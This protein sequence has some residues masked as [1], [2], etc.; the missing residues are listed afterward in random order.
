MIKVFN[1]KWR[2]IG[3]KEPEFWMKLDFRFREYLHHF[4]GAQLGVF[5]AITLHTDENGIAYPSYDLLEKETGYGRDTIGRALNK[6]CKTKINDQRVLMRFRERNDNGQYEGSNRYLIF[7]LE[8][9]IKNQ[10]P[11]LPTLEKSNSGKLI[12]EERTI[13]KEKTNNKE[14]SF[15]DSPKNKNQYFND[16]IPENLN[17]ETFIDTWREWCEYQKLSRKKLNEK[18]AARQ[19]KLLS[20]YSTEIAVWTLEESMTRGWLGVFPQNYEKYGK[21]PESGNNKKPVED[22]PQG[23][24][25]EEWKEVENGNH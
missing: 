14:R 5:L 9:E 23:Y 19:L 2:G 10:S 25:K 7:P 17:H 6:L 13:I 16:L 15:I 22:L 8:E 1:G 11:I 3:G 12:L 21:T 20:E 18:T 4:K 24:S